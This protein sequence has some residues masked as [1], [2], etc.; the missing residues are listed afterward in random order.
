[1]TL[2]GNSLAFSLLLSEPIETTIIEFYPGTL[3]FVT[4]KGP[5]SLREIKLSL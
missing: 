4:I 2:S 5:R 3:C 1:M